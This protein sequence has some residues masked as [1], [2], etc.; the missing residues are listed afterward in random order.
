VSTLKEDELRKKNQATVEK[1]FHREHPTVDET[2]NLFTEDGVWQTGW[3]DPIPQQTQWVGQAQLKVHFTGSRRFIKKWT[4]FNLRVT[5]TL[6]PNK[7]FVEAEARATFAQPG[8]VDFTPK[9]PNRYIFI[10]NMQD[11]KIKSANEYFDRL[12]A[13]KAMGMDVPE[14]RNPKMGMPINTP[15]KQ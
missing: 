1:F 13:M 8:D 14:F 11:G 12:Y 7:F 10:F 9:I 2:I 6:D 3:D 4:W 15:P 5:P